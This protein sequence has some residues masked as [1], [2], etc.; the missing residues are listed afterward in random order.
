MSNLSINNLQL[1]QDIKLQE[2]HIGG[3]NQDTA[4]IFNNQSNILANTNNDYN[5][6]LDYNNKIEKDKNVNDNY[7]ER[8]D[9]EKHTT[10]Y[11]INNYPTYVDD[12]NYSNPIIYPKDYNMYFEY[13]HKKNINNINT[14]VIKKKNYVNIDSANRNKDTFLN[15][16][17]YINLK[18]NSLEF[19]NQTSNLK[20]YIDEPS[21][22]FKQNDC[23]ILRGFK[24]YTIF[25]EKLNFFFT[26]N[27]PIVILDLKPNFIEKIPYYDIFIKIGGVTNNE[28]KNWK[29]IPLYLINKEQKIE[30]I[31]INGSNKLSFNLPISFYS[32]NELDQ[33]LVSDCIITFTSLGN[34]PINLINSNIPI[35]VSNLNPYMII[36]EVGSNYIKVYLT[37]VLSLNDNIPL[38]GIWDNNNFRTGTN[39][40][41]GIITSFVQ[42]YPNPNS[43]VINLDQ[44]YNNVCSIK[45]ISSEIPNVIKNINGKNIFD[46]GSIKF[47]SK[48]NNRFYWDNILD[49]GIYFIELESGYYEYEQL[50]FT[51]Q[52][53]VSQVKRKFIINNLYLQDNNL[54]EIN[55]DTSTDITTVNFFNIY[56][57][58]CCLDSITELD[59]KL[60]NEILIRIYH[61]NH[62]L[63]EGDTI[64]ISDSIDYFNVKSDYINVQTGHKI[65]KV[66]NNNYYEILL[67]NINKITNVGDTKGGN[68]IKIKY[69]AIFRL[70][71]N[72][73]DTFGD[74]IGFTLT[75][76]PNSITNYSSQYPY[77]TINN[78]QPYFNDVKNIIIVNN[79]ISPF[80]LET[81]YSKTNFRYILLLAE[82]FNLNYN[83]NGQPY[84]YK[85]LLNGQA[86]SYLYNT[87]VQSPLY[88]NPPIKSITNLFFTFILPNGSPVN[89]GNLNSSFTLE[90]TTIDNIP[91]NTNISTFIARL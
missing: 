82:N 25:Y 72:F 46:I 14:Q 80:D 41:I 89:F 77:Y 84:F 56:A 74:I 64:F 49:D 24:N 39:I 8:L 16:K 38:N 91:E 33:T 58:P 30:L 88:F 61:I 42:G 19:T 71:F 81:S 5:R 22:Y 62:N 32:D 1:Y 11:R 36:N 55:F 13:L 69:A 66:I 40:Q 60:G 27:S 7:V 73:P 76:Y 20:I 47:I 44:S 68:E 2:K 9:N 43:F 59:D 45:M 29:N 79:L 28:Q 83:P 53:K 23:V 65:F 51:I 12:I 10:V 48:P 75:G 70:F 6:L 37:N 50:K 86:N 85:L 90:I 35:N 34:Y 52:A 78:L 87:F 17:E 67:K 63:K 4:N 57:Y 15:I 21:I 3:T 54:I 31:N 26:N 18:D